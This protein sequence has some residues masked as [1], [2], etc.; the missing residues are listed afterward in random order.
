MTAARSSVHHTPYSGKPLRTRDRRAVNVTDQPP[1]VTPS[2]GIS[3]FLRNVLY[4]E[5]MLST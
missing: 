4:Q 1:P 3:I 2:L 5:A